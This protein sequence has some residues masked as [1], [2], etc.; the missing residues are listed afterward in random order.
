[1]EG[2][3]AQDEQGFL[4]ELGEGDERLFGV[5]QEGHAV[6]AQEDGE[7]LLGL[8]D[9]LGGAA[10]VV[11]ELVVG[12]LGAVDV[13]G[14]QQQFREGLPD[15]LPSEG[16]LGGAGHFPE[17]LG[18]LEAVFQGDVLVSREGGDLLP[19]EED[20]ALLELVVVVP[21]GLAGGAL[22]VD[23]EGGVADIG[24]FGGEVG[25]LGSCHRFLR[26]GVVGVRVHFP[27]CSSA[28]RMA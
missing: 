11:L 17:V 28:A 9:L 3:D 15:L 5:V 27:F 23:H 24:E 8:E 12:G 2:G 13:V 26:G 4:A 10:V 7:L 14:G 19:G 21:G 20:L 16:A 25:L 6:L 18:H 22:V 1:M